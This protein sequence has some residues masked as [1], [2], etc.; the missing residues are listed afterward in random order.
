MSYPES[1]DRTMRKPALRRFADAAEPCFYSAPVLLL[2]IAVMLVPLLLGLSYAFR[3]IQL[4][5]RFRA[6]SLG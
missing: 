2:I 6:L 4:L 5:N 1:V 3:D